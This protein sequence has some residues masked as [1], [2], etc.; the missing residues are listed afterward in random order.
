MEALGRV[1]N[2]ETWLVVLRQNL[3]NQNSRFVQSLLKT[4]SNYPKFSRPSSP[5]ATPGL[6]KKGPPLH[7]PSPLEERTEALAGPSIK[8]TL[9]RLDLFNIQY[10]KICS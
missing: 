6:N 1:K 8:T 3:W 9:L 5:S 10:K 4:P 7:S 2:P